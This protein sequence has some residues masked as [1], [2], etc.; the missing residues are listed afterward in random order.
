[1]GRPEK[2]YFHCKKLKKILIIKLTKIKSFIVFQN[3]FI[4]N[5]TFINDKKPINEIEFEMLD[6]LEN[7]GKILTL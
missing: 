3:S 1:M 2:Y 7:L 5:L 4:R 6:I